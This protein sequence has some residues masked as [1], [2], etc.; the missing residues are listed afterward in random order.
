MREK[1]QAE[2]S[3]LVTISQGPKPERKADIKYKNTLIER[4]FFRTEEGYVGLGPYV[5][6]PGD[7][8]GVLFGI[9]VPYILRPVHEGFLLIGECY[10]HGVMNG[11][12]LEEGLGKKRNFKIL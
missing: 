9:N 5:I 3:K 8:V 6:Q 11:E 12:K 7:L 2:V 1:W 4:S 10:V